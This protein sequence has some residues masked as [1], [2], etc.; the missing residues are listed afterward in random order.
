MKRLLDSGYFWIAL[1]SLLLSVGVALIITF[2]SWPHPEASTTESNSETIRNVGL[3]LAGVL[4]FVFALWRAW[5]AERQAATARDQ[6]KI[7]Q[8]QAATAERGLLNERYQKGA[9][10]L[11]SDVLSVRLGGIY[12]LQRLADEQPKQYHVQIM[13]LFCAFVRNPNT[14]REQAT[15][16]RAATTSRCLCRNACDRCT[17]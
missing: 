14:G 4:A 1:S 3:L 8:E 13:R 16:P 7:A 9:E 2:W 15:R 5:V 12:A 11:G 17:R 6:A 10:M